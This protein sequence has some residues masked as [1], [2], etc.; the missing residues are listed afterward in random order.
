MLSRRT[1]RAFTIIELLLV[2]TIM[3]I[4]VAVIAPSLTRSIRGN[5]LRTASR[6]VVMAGRYARSMAVLKQKE[7]SMVF[8]L[9]SATVSVSGELTRQLD[10]V[11]IKQVDVGGADERTFTKGSCSIAYRNNGTFEPYIVI[12]VDERG[13]TT[14][15]T[16][17]SL[18]SAE[19]RT[20]NR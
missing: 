1:G 4:V 19:T 6:T 16:V 2:L 12:L 7:L 15:I 13:V 5:R 18:S 3:G 8:N 20:E 10:E 11:R 17:D 14:I 9:E